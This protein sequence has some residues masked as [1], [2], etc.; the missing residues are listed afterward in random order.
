[1]QPA[2]WLQRTTPLP[3]LQ[4]NPTPFKLL[5]GR[6]VHSQIDEV[7]PELETSDFLQHGGL[8]NFF[9]D[10]KEAW[11]EV[12]RERD[13]LL[14]RRELRQHQRSR[15]N[16]DIQRA[17]AKPR[18]GD[19]VMVQEADSTL[20]HEGVH[21]KLVHEKWAGPWK[22]SAVITP[23]L[24]Y[25]VVL[26]GSQV[27]ERWAAAFY[28]KPFHFRPPGLRHDFGNQYA[29]FA[30]DADLGLATPFHSGTP[31]VHTG[32]QPG[33]GKK[34]GA[35]WRWEYKRRFLIRAESGW[36][37]RRMCWTASHRCNW[38][39]SMRCGSYTTATLAAPG[40]QPLQ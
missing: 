30:W 34:S 10:R 35:A 37:Q 28:I 39:S 31:V 19:L 6:D 32:G 33:V 14:K 22:V 13:V 36:N 5:F 15:S 12:T 17:S 27:R 7:T 16:A 1:M 40:H 24:C 23:G 8:P 2:L 9:A 25:H 26:N 21:R 4:G 20:W 11:R 38:T 29:H 18:K 3:R